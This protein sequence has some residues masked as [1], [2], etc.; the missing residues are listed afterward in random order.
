V[1]T[2]I[3]YWK[4][5]LVG[6]IGMVVQLGSLALFNRWAPS[7]YLCAT[8]A[9]IEITLLHNFV[10]HL[11]YTWRD[12]RDDSSL[13]T[14]LVRFHLSNGLVSM[15]GNLALMRI[16]VHQAHLPVLV[17][18]SIAILCCSIVNFCLGNCWAFARQHPKGR[19]NMQTQPRQP[20]TRAN[21]RRL[22]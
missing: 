14:Q 9:A 6:A 3:R 13:V 20:L 11:R 4:F 1:N 22:V 19:C 8:A 18:N 5:N 16:L 10:W 21:W 15:L 7:H 2:F 12:R 17:A